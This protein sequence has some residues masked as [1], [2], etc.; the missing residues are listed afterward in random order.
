MSYPDIYF[1]CTGFLGRFHL[2]RCRNAKKYYTRDKP[3]AG[4]AEPKKPTVSTKGNAEKSKDKADKKAKKDKK[5]KKG[6]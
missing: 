2:N 3:G 6:K 4:S 1:H 5:N